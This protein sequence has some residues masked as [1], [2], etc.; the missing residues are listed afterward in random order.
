MKARMFLLSLIISTSLFSKPYPDE[1]RVPK[2]RVSYQLKKTFK[3]FQEKALPILRV[4]IDYLGNDH[5][6]LTQ[7]KKEYSGTQSFYQRSLREDIHGSYKGILSNGKNTYHDSVGLGAT[8]KDLSRALTFRFPHV[9]DLSSYKLIFVRENPRTGVM[10]KKIELDL[11]DSEVENLEDAQ[12][13][14]RVLR[15]VKSSQYLTLTVYAEGYLKNEES[16]FFQDA[17]KVVKSLEQN[18][19]PGQEQFKILAYFEPSHTKLGKAKNL[20]L[21]IPERDSFL[22][23]YFPY[24]ESFGRWYHVLYPTREERFRDGIGKAPY[25]YPLIV[26]NDKEYWGV[27]NYRELT[28]IPSDNNS[29]SYLLFHEFGHFL[30]LNEEYEEVGGRTELAFAP[31][32]KEPWSPNITF[33]TDPKKLKWS[34]QVKVG[35]PIPTDKTFWSA[36]SKKYGAYKGGYAGA[37]PLGLSHKPGYSCLMESGKDFC[38]ICKE[39]ILNRLK[40]DQ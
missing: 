14:L 1:S 23:L 34:H 40:L 7:L 39:A 12:G 18:A 15:D 29:F 36:I 8:Y 25:D 38:S 4:Q 33:N 37:E 21:P 2:D 24:W 13:T 11:T 16:K 19:F 31:G 9:E 32:I 20:G 26:V 22:G 17:Q 27:G 6:V 5:F 30:G 28:A 10:E 35:T 3:K